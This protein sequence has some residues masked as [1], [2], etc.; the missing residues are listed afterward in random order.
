[1][2]WLI[3]RCPFGPDEDPVEHG[4]DLLENEAIRA[5][6]PLSGLDRKILCSENPDAEPIPEELRQRVKQLIARIFETEPWDEF[7]SKP[8]GLQ[9]FVRMGERFTL[10]KYCDACRGSRLRDRVSIAAFA[11]MGVGQGQTSTGGPC[12]LVH[13]DNRRQYCRHPGPVRVEVKSTCTDSKEQI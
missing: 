13:R 8:K 2:S 1:M 3:K 4:V 10:L 11:R 9:Q 5:G 12:G 6:F 7:E